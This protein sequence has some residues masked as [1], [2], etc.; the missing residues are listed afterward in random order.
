VT[1]FLRYIFLISFSG[2]QIVT[3]GCKTTAPAGSSKTTSIPE[4]ESSCS[5]A[6]KDN[7]S[8]SS[9]GA[10]ALD[11][12]LWRVIASTAMASR[13]AYGNPDEIARKSEEWG[14]TAHDI[15]KSSSMSAVILSNR[16][17]VVLAFRGTDMYELRDWVVDLRMRPE[18][19]RHG[20]MHRGFLEAWTGLRRE[21][22][23]L[24]NRHGA[25]SKT[26]WVTG[27]S[28]GG[29][30]AGVYAHSE[31]FDRLIFK[32]PEIHRIVTFGQPMFANESLAAVMRNEFLGKYFRVV[33]ELDL[34]ATIPWR[35]A[36]FGSLVWFHADTIEYRPDVRL[37]GGTGN[38]GVQSAEIPPE[39]APTEQNM[40]EFLDATSRT[41]NRDDE[42]PDENSGDPPTN[43]TTVGWPKRISDHFMGGYL[44][45]L[46]IELESL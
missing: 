26:F 5:F 22:V 16:K 8:Y 30:L 11:P 4:A 2:I 46:R 24:L 41:S 45:R 44:E 3:P 31:T 34:V 9:Q 36:H 10:E 40:R 12:D 19:V 20:A 1:T 33:N 37:V 43:P 39:L 35:F 27:H 25:G 7:L 6:T 28:L 21:V 18:R 38:I 42:N 17:C 29:A 15:V 32:G 23:A 14:F 13:L